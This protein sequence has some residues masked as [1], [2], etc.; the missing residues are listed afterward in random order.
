MKRAPLDPDTARQVRDVMAQARR[1]GRDPVEALNAAGLV[2]SP[3]AVAQVKGEALYALLRDVESWRPA[4]YVRRV[5]KATAPTAADM[6]NAILGYIAE[7][8]E[9][10]GRK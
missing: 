7:Y 9:A 8:V 5:N 10:G 6:Y 2:M 3:A 1:N 4:E